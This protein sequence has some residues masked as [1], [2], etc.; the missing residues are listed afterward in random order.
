MIKTGYSYNFYGG[1]KKY[2]F[3]LFA[4]FQ[5]ISAN[6]QDSTRSQTIQIVSSYKPVL[7]PGAKLNFSASP[8]APVAFTEKFTYAL[9]DQ[10]YKVFMKSV[11]LVPA[12]FVPD[13]IPFYNQHFFKV[14]YGN[15]QRIYADAGT[16]WGAGK[17]IQ[18]QLFAGYH[19]Q[20]GKLLFQQTNRTYAQTNV[21]YFFRK[22]MLHITA[23]ANRNTF[24]YYGNQQLRAAD[25]KD[26]LRIDYDNWSVDLGLKNQT[27]N[28]YGLTYAP[29]LTFHLLKSSGIN[30]INALVRLP[31]TVNINSKT[32]FSLQTNTDLTRFQID[33]DTMYSNNIFSVAPSIRFPVKDLSFNAGAQF[34]WDNSNLQLLPQFGMEAFVKSNQVIILAGVESR[35]SKNNF[36]TLSR[37]NPWVAPA[38]SQINTR[39]DDYFVGLRGSFSW[40]LNYRVTTGISNFFNQPLFVNTPKT[41]VFSTLHEARLQTYHIKANAEWLLADIITADIGFDFYHFVKQK[42][43]AK[44]WHFIPAELYLNTRWKPVKNLMLQTKIFAWSGPYVKIDALHNY[45]KLSSVF[46]ANI[47]ADFR[48]S[49]LFLIWMQL[50]NIFNQTYERWNQYNVLGFQIVGGIRLNF[51][52]KK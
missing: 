16:S 3:F 28:T 11:E 52:Q 17:P 38:R 33:G 22:H 20:Q 49:K 35:I 25:K 23:D 8:V 10:Q 26:S 12:S 13:S 42:Q 1:L 37:L 40:N 19:A 41:A 46:D 18:I 31:V 14:G 39:I 51:D 30:E 5:F 15:Y 34:V 7:K 9:P 47:E 50:N 48:V 27:P 32:S 4:F 29:S 24:Y 36:S 45:K 2:V 21:Q 6:A 43:E 44:P